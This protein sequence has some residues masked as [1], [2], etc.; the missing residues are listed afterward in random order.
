MSG[1]VEGLVAEWLA[2]G[3]APSGSYEEGYCD[4]RRHAAGEL[5]SALADAQSV[6][7]WGEV[8]PKWRFLARG[9]K[10]LHGDEL[11]LDNCTHWE[12]ATGFSVGMNYDPSIFVPVRRIATQ[13]GD[14]T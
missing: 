6:A 4:A 13:H 9:E 1:K 10:I 12:P 7:A 3:S 8:A 11:L 14:N 2:M 5:K